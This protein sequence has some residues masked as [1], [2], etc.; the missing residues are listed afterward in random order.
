MGTGWVEETALPRDALHL[1]QVLV[2]LQQLLVVRRS[3][4]GEAR[5]ND[6]QTHAQRPRPGVA[7][8]LPLYVRRGRP[9][10][11]VELCEHDAAQERRDRDDVRLLQQAPE[12]ESEEQRGPLLRTGSERGA[13]RVRARCERGASEVRSDAP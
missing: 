11:A 12:H 5:L 7:L 6:D 2:P 8:G 9:G 13:N 4:A 10:D 1:L 3:K